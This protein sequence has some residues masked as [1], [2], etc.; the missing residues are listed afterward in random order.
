[1]K[2]Y[3]KFIILGVLL[4]CLI[5]TI[6]ITNKLI[7]NKNTCNNFELSDIVNEI[8]INTN[9]NFESS[10]RNDIYT[11][12]PIEISDET[13]YVFGNVENNTEYYM[14]IQNLNEKDILELKKFIDIKNSKYEKKQ[15]K[16]ETR[17]EYTYVILSEKY[18]TVIEGI[19]RSYIYCN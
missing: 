4:L 15:I 7:K 18:S 9:H 19:I 12:I 6:L 14:I 3:M 16:M 2:K 8:N 11:Y 10:L 5:S 17:G 13:N 1:M